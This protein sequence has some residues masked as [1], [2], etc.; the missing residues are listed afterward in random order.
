MA[1]LVRETRRD[2][3]AIGNPI[4]I[5]WKSSVLAGAGL[6]LMTVAAYW[7]VYSGKFVWDD[8]SWTTKIAGLLHD[9]SGLRAIWFRPTALQQYYPLAGTSFW[10]DYQ[11]W[12]FWPLPYHVENVLLHAC[13]AVLFWRLLK[14][15]SVP[16]AWVAAAIF[17]V[18]PV[19]VESAGWITERKNV[20]SLVLFLGALLAYGRFNSFYLERDEGLPRRWGAYAA[21]LVL[22]AVAMLTKTTAFALPA[23]IL[24]ICWWKRGRVRWREDVLAT[25]PFFAVSVG[26]CAATAWLEKNHAGAK[27]AEWEISFPARCLIAGRVVWFYVGK[28][29]WPANLCFI[30]PRWRVDTHSLL[31]WLYP[32]SAVGV[33]I[34]LWVARGR[35]GRGPITAA[36][37]FVGTLLPV[38]G[39]MNAYFMRFSF[40]C[41]HWV[42]LSSLGLF[43]LAGAG[44][45][46]VGE[47]F[48]S[49]AVIYGFAGV[50][51]PVLA[52]MTWRQCGTYADL[53]T[54]WR[55]TLAVNPGAWM[56]HYNLGFLLQTS[57]NVAEA[58]EQY[59]QA[60]FYNPDCAE[61]GNNL[62]WILGTAQPGEGRDGDRAV[63]LAEH[64]CE[65]TG[66]NDP[67]YLDTL[68]VAYAAEG[69][70]AQAEE[71]TERAIGL[72]RS[73]GEAGLIQRMQDRLALYR[74]NRAVEPR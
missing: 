16:G 47:Y 10:I 25:I 30:Y 72:A 57:G 22:F 19:M 60:L 70:F 7:P 29:V 20:L 33:L 48:G 26:L 64:A 67:D 38:L 69:K 55:D 39:F 54:L 5:D 4:K 31:Q 15:F 59:E 58:R 18:H 36:L 66:N 9:F 46:R 68:G 21:A 49:R 40:V 74:A 43:A 50:V 41:D 28:L 73:A 61:A 35:I 11:V 53:E 45:A 6:V 2:R 32:I 23:V 63:R 65:L 44:V 42:Y 51:L 62:A 17:A 8:D 24:L 13:A 52:L 14:R 27:G 56:A 12:G 37:F 34:A 71:V 1:L 3:E